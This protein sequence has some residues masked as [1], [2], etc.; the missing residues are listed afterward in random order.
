[1]HFR[2]TVW[3]A[4]VGLTLLSG[5]GTATTTAPKTVTKH[6][7]SYVDKRTKA[8]QEA[9]L[10]AKAESRA[11]AASA[12]KLREQA[13]TQDKASSEASSQSSQLAESRESA[14]VESEKAASSSEKAASALAESQATQSSKAAESAASSAKAASAAASSTQ[15][16]AASNATGGGGA[17]NFSGDTDTAQNGRI[18]GNSR[19][20]IYHVETQHNYHM[21]GKNVVT[22]SSEAEA[23]AAGYRKSMR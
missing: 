22:F 6:Q 5:C 12:K 14:K 7:I 21:S 23:Q 2:K 8:D 19:S 9:W 13:S 11:N 20:K 16:S 4:V 17:A 15:K 3:L 1:M 18:I 10:A